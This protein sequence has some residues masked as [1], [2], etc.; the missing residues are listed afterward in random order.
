MFQEKD[1]AINAMDRPILCYVRALTSHNML[2][3]FE[4]YI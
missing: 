3:A 1:V 2:V 4:I